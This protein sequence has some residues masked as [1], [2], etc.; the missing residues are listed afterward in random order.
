MWAEEIV[1]FYQRH[2]IYVIFWYPCIPITEFSS[3]E[4][5][6]SY[7]NCL[8]QHCADQGIICV[9][10]HQIHPYPFSFLSA[11]RTPEFL[12]ENFLFSLSGPG[13]ALLNPVSSKLALLP[14]ATQLPLSR[15]QLG[16]RL[17]SFLF[18]GCTI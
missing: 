18:W 14:G 15:E 12:P 11:S 5:S 2:A 3:W 16:H 17:A 8:D 10:T 9:P 4:E 1:V 7:L 13:C 6:S